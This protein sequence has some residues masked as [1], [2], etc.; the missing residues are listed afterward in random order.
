MGGHVLA[1][2]AYGERDLAQ[3][4]PTGKSPR[5]DEVGLAAPRQRLQ[6]G[7]EVGGQ[8][9]ERSPAPR[10]VARDARQRG[11]QSRELASEGG[12]DTIPSLGSLDPFDI[13]SPGEL[14]ASA[15]SHPSPAEVLDRITANFDRASAAA[16]QAA[17]PSRSASPSKESPRP[18]DSEPTLPSARAPTESGPGAPSDQETASERRPRV[19]LREGERLL[20]GTGSGVVIRRARR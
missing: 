2:R 16:V 6:S 5:L 15:G 14:L 10:M 8:T 11:I 17:Q 3:R 18:D 12:P 13:T 20:S 19:V 9:L 4:P 7:A 1:L